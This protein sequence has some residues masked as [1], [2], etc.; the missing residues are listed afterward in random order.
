MGASPCVA[1]SRLLVPR[2]P[3]LPALSAQQTCCCCCCCGCP[4]ILQPLLLFC[5][6]T[7]TC[8]LLC[9]CSDALLTLLQLL[10]ASRY[11]ALPQPD[12]L[13]RQPCLSFF[14]QRHS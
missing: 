8:T 5:C 10:L 3:F 6:C 4:D 1:D 11:S 7:D 14:E 2:R 9:G 13:N 12:L